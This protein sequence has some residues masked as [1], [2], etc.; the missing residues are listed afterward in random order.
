MA[1]NNQPAPVANNGTVNR[2][3]V[4]NAPAA[5]L[6]PNAPAAG[7]PQP[8]QQLSGPVNPNNLRNAYN[9]LREERRDD[10]IKQQQLDAAG[11]YNFPDTA[12][13]NITDTN[14]PSAKKLTVFFTFW[15]V[16]ISMAVY[17][18]VF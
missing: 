1:N 6:Q 3:V 15:V 17:G 14:N 2:P 4:A 13:D 9:K 11:I 12:T 10:Y 8:L 5:Q 7:N 18:H 16:L